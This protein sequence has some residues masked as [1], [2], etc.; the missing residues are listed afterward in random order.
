V[1]V[2]RYREMGR[3]HSRLDATQSTRAVYFVAVEIRMRDARLH[4][5]RLKCITR[6]GLRITC[7]DRREFSMRD[8][9]RK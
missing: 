4:S 1:S 2:A 5:E 3:Q 7:Y 6:R 8:L 9:E